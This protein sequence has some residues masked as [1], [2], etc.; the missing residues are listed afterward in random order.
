MRLVI[1]DG[2]IYCV[3]RNYFFDQYGFFSGIY[4]GDKY[5]G[6]YIE[7]IVFFEVKLYFFIFG[8]NIQF[9][10]YIFRI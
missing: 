8:F 3:N 2:V 7:I 4:L 6:V 9:N 1:Q 10:V 5:S